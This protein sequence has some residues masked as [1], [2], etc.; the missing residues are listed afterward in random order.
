MEKTKIEQE[1]ACPEKRKRYIHPKSVV[2]SCYCITRVR[3]FLD[4]CLKR[5]WA[6]KSSKAVL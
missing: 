5:S 6:K 3:L 2:G 4:F 1:E